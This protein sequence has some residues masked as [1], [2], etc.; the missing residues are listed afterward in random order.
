MLGVGIVAWDDIQFTMTASAHFSASYLATWLERWEDVW[1][2]AQEETSSPVE[3][4]FAGVAMFGIWS[5][6]GHFAYNL[7]VANDPD[8]ALANVAQK[9]PVPGN[10]VVGNRFVLHDYVART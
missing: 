6:L 10:E 1:T 4:K 2:Q 8:D 7:Q 3:P 5:I 9:T